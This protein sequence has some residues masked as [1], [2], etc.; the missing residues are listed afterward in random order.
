MRRLTGFL[1]IVL[2][3]TAWPIQQNLLSYISAAG[4]IRT[5]RRVDAE[6]GIILTSNSS[7]PNVRG[8]SGLL[9]GFDLYYR[10]NSRLHPY[11]IFLHDCHFHCL[12]SVKETWYFSTCKPDDLN[13]TSLVNPIDNASHFRDRKV[14]ASLKRQRY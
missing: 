7:P 4:L 1:A 8:C 13:W 12:R 5:F 2:F 11:C 10:H 14:A 3:A 6:D 9:R